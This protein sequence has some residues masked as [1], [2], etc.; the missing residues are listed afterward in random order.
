MKF[1]AS[2]SCG[3][4]SLAMVYK[5]MEEKLP[6]DE[7]VFYDTG[8]EFKAIYQNWAKLTA[9]A[10]QRGI[11]CVT[12]RPKCPFKYMM[13]D[14]PHMSR[15]DGVTYYGYS[16]CGGRCRWGT[17]EKLKAI[18]SY[19][20]R[21]DVICYIG[22]AADETNRLNK[23]RKP[24]KRF[25]LADWGMTEADCLAY[26]RER[27]IDWIEY[28]ELGRGIDLY[29]ILDRVSCWC[30]ANKNLWELYNIWKYLPTYWEGLCEIQR[31]TNRPFKSN[32]SIFQIQERFESGY[33]PRHRTREDNKQ[34]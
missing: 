34:T 7:I 29:D 2:C 8:M 13:F 26:C 5:I 4:D 9:Y 1:I 30:C 33:I 19:C 3:K 20:E 32:Q 18:D 31:R 22:I 11:K 21:E 27:G 6:L 28:S 16:W 12:L 25:P 15:K 23:E 24:Y 14:H 17:T 10:E